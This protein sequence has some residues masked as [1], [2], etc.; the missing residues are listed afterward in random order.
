VSI[1]HAAEVLE[2]WNLI[3]FQAL[4]FKGQTLL[5]TGPGCPTEDTESLEC[6][7]DEEEDK[8]CSNTFRTWMFPHK[9]Q[10]CCRTSVSCL[11]ISPCTKVVTSG[12]N[13]NTISLWDTATQCR[14]HILFGHTGAVMKYNIA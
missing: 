11:S 5:S 4:R 7:D 13:D 3:G 14:K 1:S 6:V 8:S 12:Q 2:N 9:E 10:M